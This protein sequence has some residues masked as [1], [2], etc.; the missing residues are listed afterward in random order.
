[1][2]ETY[3][4]YVSATVPG[5]TPEVARGIAEA[6]TAGLEK[7]G[8]M[9]VPKEYAERHSAM[10]IAAESEREWIKALLDYANGVIDYE[11]LEKRGKEIRPDSRSEFTTKCLCIIADLNHEPSVVPTDKGKMLEMLSKI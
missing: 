10:M 9:T 4:E 3:F 6:E 11:G 1:M 2:I 7:F 8:K 5:K